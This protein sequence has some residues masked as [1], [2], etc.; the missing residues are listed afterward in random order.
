M[1]RKFGP[2]EDVVDEL[3]G[4]HTV[5]GAAKRL[6]LSPNALDTYIDRKQI[7]CKVVGT[8][9]LVTLDSLKPYADKVRRRTM[10]AMERLETAMEPGDQMVMSDDQIGGDD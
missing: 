2:H 4:W 1:A 10:A 9:R 8:T 7:R 5:K 6:G 3:C